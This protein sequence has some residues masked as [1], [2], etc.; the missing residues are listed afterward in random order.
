MPCDV[1]GCTSIKGLLRFTRVGHCASRKWRVRLKGMGETGRGGQRRLGSHCVQCRGMRNKCVRRAVWMLRQKRAMFERDRNQSIP[2]RRTLYQR[3]KLLLLL[4]VAR[5]LFTRRGRLGP[6]RQR[7]PAIVST[8][9]G[10]RQT[11]TQPCIQRSAVL[12][13]DCAYKHPAAAYKPPV[14]IIRPD[15]LNERSGGDAS[16]TAREQE[17]PSACQHHVV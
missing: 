11:P 4:T 5:H 13:L 3:L 15:M 12:S 16:Q 8:S 9:D 6:T 7:S 14:A 17:Q 10:T 1:S 2:S